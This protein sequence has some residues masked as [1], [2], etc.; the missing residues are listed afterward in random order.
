M[1]DP[2]Y[3]SQNDEWM[4]AQGRIKPSLDRALPLSEAAEAHRLISTHKVTGTIV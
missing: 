1:S 4:A 3:D 2:W